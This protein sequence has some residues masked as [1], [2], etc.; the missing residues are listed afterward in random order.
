[1]KSFE[2]RNTVALRKRVKKVHAKARFVG[3]LYLLGT[4]A[5][6]LLACLP[7]LKINEQELSV[8]TFLPSI[9]ALIQGDGELL[10]AI[11]SILYLII[12]F[13]S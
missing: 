1:M 5:I 12:F 10:P 8:T 13:F 4:L 7:M 6:A 9:M 3:V 2:S 11:T